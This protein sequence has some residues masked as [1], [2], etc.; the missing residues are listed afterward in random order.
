[1]CKTYLTDLVEHLEPFMTYMNEQFA[2]TEAKLARMR[3]YGQLEFDILLYHFEPGMK[4]VG[5]ECGTGRPD[6]FVLQSRS[7][8][9][10]FSGSQVLRLRGYAYRFNGDQ[11]EQRFIRT[12]IEEYK[13]TQRVECLPVMELP[14]QLEE[15]LKSMWEIL[16][17]GEALLILQ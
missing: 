8:G 14:A 1:M 17:P 15:A 10:T 6:A 11:Y 12:D 13:G 5:S 9:K 16:G 4:L 7:I 3:E 2:P